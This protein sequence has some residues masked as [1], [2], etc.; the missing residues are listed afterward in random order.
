MFHKCSHG[1]FG[2]LNGLERFFLCAFHQAF[3]RPAFARDLPV[4]LSFQRHDLNSLF[5][6]GVARVGVDLLLLCP[7]ATSPTFSCPVRSHPSRSAS[8]SLLEFKD[9]AIRLV[10]QESGKLAQLKFGLMTDLLTGRVRVPE[11]ASNEFP[12]CMRS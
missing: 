11:A 8:L 4:Y 10:E 9:S 7:A 3:D 12:V 1:G 5:H 6:A 2:F